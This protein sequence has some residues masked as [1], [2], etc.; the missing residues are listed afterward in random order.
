MITAVGTESDRGGGST[1]LPLALSLRRRARVWSFANVSAVLAAAVVAGAGPLV[2]FMAVYP[3]V[4]SVAA[5]GCFLVIGSLL[6]KRGVIDHSGIVPSVDAPLLG[7]VVM[8]GAMSLT[9]TPAMSHPSFVGRAVLPAWIAGS[10][11]LALWVFGG[12]RLPLI[13]RFDSEFVSPVVVLSV[14]AGLSAHSTDR[15]WRSLALSVSAGLAALLADLKPERVAAAVGPI[16][17]RF[18]VVA[19]TGPPALR[20]GAVPALVWLMVN[21][22]LWMIG[23]MRGY[24]LVYGAWLSGITTQPRWVDGLIAVTGVLVVP[25]GVLAAGVL[26]SLNGAS[27]LVEIGRWL[28]RSMVAGAVLGFLWYWMIL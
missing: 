12:T 28:A 26:V 3:P 10:V 6:A 27:V 4:K 15:L 7:V 22:G 19:G 25:L 16:V 5:A 21:A 23:L 13:G 24:R 8:V 18:R 14:I 9:A 20:V 11:A 17:S 1:H 2:R